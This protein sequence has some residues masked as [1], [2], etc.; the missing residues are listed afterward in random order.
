MLRIS[1]SV[2]GI[3]VAPPTPINARAA[4]STSGFGA[5]AAR[6]EAAPKT[7]APISKSLRL[8]MRS[9]MLPI[10]IRSP[11]SRNPYASRIHSV[12]LA[13]GAKS[14][15]MVG[16]AM[17]RI[18]MSID[19]RITGSVNTARPSHRDREALGDGVGSCM[20]TS[21]HR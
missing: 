1:D 15:V 13:D 8:P 3:R 7:T 18:V 2:E 10:T 19:V 4:M 21:S 6:A 16:M 5:N 9:P 11:A 17:C 20:M 12:W 14:R